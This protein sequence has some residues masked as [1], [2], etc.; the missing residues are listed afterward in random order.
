MGLV[1]IASLFHALSF[2][3]QNQAKA[4]YKN[5]YLLSDDGFDWILL[6]GLYWLPQ[7]IGLFSEAGSTLRAH[8]ISD[9]PDLEETLNLLELLRGTEESF[10]RLG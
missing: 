3:A 2:Q 9:S 6:I 4:T 5:G 7:K 1:N 10:A 8:K